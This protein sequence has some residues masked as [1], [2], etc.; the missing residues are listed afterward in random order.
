MKEQVYSMSWLHCMCVQIIVHES[1]YNAQII[2]WYCIVVYQHQ[3][4]KQ[5]IYDIRSRLAELRWRFHSSMPKSIR[6]SLLAASLSLSRWYSMVSRIND[7]CRALSR[8][9]A[10]IFPLHPPLTNTGFKGRG[11]ESDSTH[12]SMNGIEC[13][14]TRIT[15]AIRWIN[16]RAFQRVSHTYC[17]VKYDLKRWSMKISCK[18]QS[19]HLGYV[20]KNAPFLRPRLRAHSNTPIQNVLPGHLWKYTKQ[21]RWFSLSSPQTLWASTC[22]CNK[23]HTKNHHLA[24][25]HTPYL[26]GQASNTNSTPSLICLP[27]LLTHVISIWSTFIDIYI[28]FNFKTS[29]YIYLISFPS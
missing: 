26:H 27:P 2:G 19:T 3:I 15:S 17:T 28:T 13:I 18:G 25:I 21:G 22:D 12:R 8:L 11:G 14:M 9:H 6:L 20:Y 16:Y 29:D 4:V 1:W 5:Y 10:D 23:S 7:D 24:T